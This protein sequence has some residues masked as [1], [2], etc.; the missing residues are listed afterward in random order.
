MEL[1]IIN[2]KIITN[3]ISNIIILLILP[4]RYYNEILLLLLSFFYSLFKFNF[5]HCLYFRSILANNS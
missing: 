1:Y 5:A 2:K 3:I 4:I